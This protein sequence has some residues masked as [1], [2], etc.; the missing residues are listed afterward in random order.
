[1]FN[2]PHLKYPSFLSDF[3]DTRIFPTDL[4]CNMKFRENLFSGGRIVPCGQTD[5]CDEANSRFS[6]FFESAYTLKGLRPPKI[7]EE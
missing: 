7:A 6:Q 2:A 1:M 5:G 4:F 3:H